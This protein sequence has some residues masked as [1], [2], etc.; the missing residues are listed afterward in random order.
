MKVKCRY[1]EGFAKEEATHGRIIDQQGQANIVAQTYLEIF[2]NVWMWE[3]QSYCTLHQRAWNSQKL[4]NE[5]AKAEIM[6]YWI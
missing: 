1:K 6:N 2:W 5:L 4:L 3:D